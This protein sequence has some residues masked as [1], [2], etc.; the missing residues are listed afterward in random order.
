M[1]T[2]PLLDKIRRIPG[3]MCRLPSHGLHYP[4]GMFADNVTNGDVEV[5]PVSAYDE[6]LLKSTEL[7]IS[8]EG[9]FYLF[10]RKIP[11]I[12]KPRELYHKD[13][14][15]LLAVL[16]KVSRGDE[17]VV[18]YTHKC[19]EAK[20]HNYTIPISQFIKATKRIDP[21][22]FNNTFT[23]PCGSVVELAG[24]RFVDVLEITQLTLRLSGKESLSAKDIEDAT[25]N[26]ISRTIKSVDGVTDPIFIQE[27]L[28]EIPSTYRTKIREQLDKLSA[29]W[30][31]D[32]K[33]TTKCKDCGEEIDLSPMLNP[34][35][36]F[37]LP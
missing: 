8:G 18:P 4:E 13:V 2:N 21:T 30:G 20:N 17:L 27:W 36:F 22:Q 24:A 6:I 11:S 5:F 15:F 23:L 19:E 1:S 26:A 7:L 33:Y 31:T 9:I 14:D 10:E 12:L 16:R 34:V 32:F 28:V 25:V 35:S 37:M 3:E 29:C